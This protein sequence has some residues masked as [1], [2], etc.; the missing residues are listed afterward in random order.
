[1]NL[2][3]QDYFKNFFKSF[4][5]IEDILFKDIDNPIITFDY[6]KYLTFLV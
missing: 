2:L 5:F 1:M 4:Q 6:T 3:I